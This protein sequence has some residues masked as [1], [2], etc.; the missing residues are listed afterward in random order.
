MSSSTYKCEFE[1]FDEKKHYD[2]DSGIVVVD[3]YLSKC[4]PCKKL[5]PSIEKLAKKYRDYGVKFVGLNLSSELGHEFG[6]KWEISS[7]PKFAIVKNGKLVKVVRTDH[8]ENIDRKLGKMTGHK[9]DDH[10]HS[11]YGNGTGSR[12]EGRSRHGSDRDSSRSHRGDESKSS[13]SSKSS[14]SSKKKSSK[15]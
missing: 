4:P 5:A 15:K 2:D 12:S 3:F 13:R 9:S 6:K 7:A 14:K 1:P 8:E 11:S 10:G